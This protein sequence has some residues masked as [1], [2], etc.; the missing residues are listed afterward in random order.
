MSC[1]ELDTMVR[2]AFRGATYHWGEAE[3]AGKAAVWLARRDVP[4]LGD[5]LLL[6]KEAQANLASMRPLSAGPLVRSGGKLLCPVLAGISLLDLAAGLTDGARI[7]YRDL[8]FPSLFAP[9]VSW[10]EEISALQLELQQTDGVGLMP[11]SKVSTR[12]ELGTV[13]VTLRAIQ[14]KKLHVGT[15]AD[16]SQMPVVDTPQWEKLSHFAHLTYVPATQASRL[17]GAGAGVADND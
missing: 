15:A 2:K 16:S 13:S 14:P 9:F 1:N 10:A 6:L 17:F 4:F 8:G 12:A 11:F 5:M 3:E 7:E